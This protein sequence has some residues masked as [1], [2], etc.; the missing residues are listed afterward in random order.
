MGIGTRVIGVSDDDETEIKRA[1]VLRLANN[2][3]QALDLDARLS[4]DDVDVIASS[5]NAY[6]EPD[7]EII[8]GVRLLASKEGVIADPVYEGR[9]IR[10][11]MNLVEEGRFEDDAKILLMHLGGSPAIHAYAGHFGSIELQQFHA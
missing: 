11:L 7:A 2:A 1:R 8:R 10:G 9:A 4:A 3:L 5:P 6:G